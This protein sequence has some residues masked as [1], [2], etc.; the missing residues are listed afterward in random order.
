MGIDL[1]TMIKVPG[2]LF[3]EPDNTTPGFYFGDVPR[4]NLK[5]YEKLLSEVIFGTPQ[6]Q[7]KYRTVTSG[8]LLELNRPRC[9]SFLQ[10]A[11]LI[12][13]KLGSLLHIA[14][15]GPYRGTEYATTCIRNTVNGNSRNVKAVLGKLC[16]VSG[17]NKTSFAVGRLPFSL[18]KAVTDFLHPHDRRKD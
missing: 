13:S 18:G 16:L 10:E 1:E 14:T 17:Y 2:T 3:D 4:N 5:R 8:G 15:A 6:L 11:A 7:Q 12:R 9:Y